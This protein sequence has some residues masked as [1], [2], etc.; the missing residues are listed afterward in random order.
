MRKREIPSAYL[1]TELRIQS[2]L[3]TRVLHSTFIN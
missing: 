1:I 3:S 2:I